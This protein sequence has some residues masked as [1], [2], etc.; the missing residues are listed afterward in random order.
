MTNRLQKVLVANRGEIAV[1]VIRALRERGIVSVAVYSEA[2]RDGLA[3]Q[4]ADEAHCIGPAPSIESY[5][6]APKIVDLASRVGA[7]A[8]HPGYGFLSE[9]AD[10]AR[11][12]EERGVTFIGPSS[13]AIAAMGSKI[14][15]RRLMRAA[16]VPIVPGGTEPLADA[17]A[18]RAAARKIGYPVML[19]AS[20]GGGGKGMRLVH[21]EEELGAAFRGASSEAGAS[22]NDPSVYV[23]RFVERPRHVEIQVLGDHSGRIVSLGEREC[24]LQRRHQKVVEE[25]P[26]PVVD[27]D[28][29]RRMGEAAVRAAEAV[30]YV[31]AGTVEFLLDSDGE[32]Y[33][34]EM[35]TRIQ[36][37]HPV[38]ELVTGVDIVAA[39]LDIA[40]GEP[41]PE[42]LLGG[43]E[44]RGHAVEV[45]LYA[46]DPFRG[47]APSPGKIELLRLPEG[48]GVR[49]DCGVYE[50]AEVTIHYDPMLA[51][52]IVWGRDRPQALARLRRAL[53]ETRVEGIRTNLA[54]FE[55]LLE[56]DDFL[57]GNM[58]ISMLDRKLENGDLRAPTPREDTLEAD[59]PVVAA[60]LAHLGR[61][62]PNGA[63]ATSIGATAR[64]NW[65]LAARRE[66]RRGTTWN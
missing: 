7:D 43:I 39:Q 57:A 47:F 3:T 26:S 38:T 45:R 37:E 41:L 33:F 56:D 48:P 18:A 20:A 2:D 51:K 49:N 1:R 63:A 31:G 23:E 9:N 17:E 21:E 28:L 15:S 52:L 14:E 16:G 59:L 10:F 4:M 12:C 27:T 60:V 25:A 61:T 58:D 42:A 40:A 44:P 46:E 50:G 65:Q 11:R 36:V 66:S 64:S 24:S 6:R 8:I 29:R 35:N 34:L 30:N 13:E 32:F 5:L 19:K 22:F 54:L 55:L 53:A 62:S